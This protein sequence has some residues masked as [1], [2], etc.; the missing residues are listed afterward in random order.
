VSGA[1]K[2]SDEWAGEA[3]F[4]VVVET[5]VLSEAEPSRACREKELYAEQVKAWKQDRAAGFNSNTERQREAAKQSRAGKKQVRQL[6]KAL[7][8]KD[9]VLSC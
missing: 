4:A 6:E 3:K 1:N 7:R 8:R 2:T 5:A 9:R